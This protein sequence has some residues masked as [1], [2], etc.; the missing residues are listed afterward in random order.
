MVTN[1]EKNIG[2]YSKERR[3]IT[4]VS[5][6]GEGQSRTGRVY[7]PLKPPSASL[8]TSR[9]WEGF[10]SGGSTRITAGR[11][12]TPRT[13]VFVSPIA[14]VLVIWNSMN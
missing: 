13:T 5:A 2:G 14:M 7:G 12:K 3:R 8:Y 11:L 1:L 4:V 10:T 6:C 9:H